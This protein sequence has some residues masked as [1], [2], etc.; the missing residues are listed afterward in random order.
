MTTMGMVQPSIHEVIDVVPVRH[1]FVPAG[2]AVLVRADR[3]R[4]ALHGID[5]A[6][7]N[8]MLIDVI[9]VRMMQMAIMKII[10]MVVMPDRRM[11]AVWTM[12]VA[13]V[14]V[15]LLG[16]GSHSLFPFLPFLSSVQAKPAVFGVRLHVQSQFPP[17]A[18]RECRRANS[19]CALPYAA[20]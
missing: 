10:D 9:L 8:G 13:M 15:M 16:A 18:E 20:F 4:R 5:R 3:L 11:P 12:H 19:R 2:R 14:G 7:C 1:R 6:D 17:N